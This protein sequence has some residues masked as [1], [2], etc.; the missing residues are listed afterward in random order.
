VNLDNRAR[1]RQE[2]R[3][4]ASPSG[5]ALPVSRRHVTFVNPEPRKG[6]HVF[7]RIAEVLSE[8][9]PD[10]PFLMV[11]GAAR[12]CLLTEIGIDLS[13]IRN[14]TVM[15]NTPDP[16]RFHAVTKLLLMPSLM[17]N[18]G[19]V[20]MEAMLNG[21]PVLASNRGGLPE[22]IGDAGFLFDIPAKYTPE[23]LDI[24]T[25]DEVEPWIETIVRLWDDEG[26]YAEWS[27]RARRRADRWRPERLAPAYREF[28]SHLCPQRGPPLLARTKSASRSARPVG[29][30]EDLEGAENPFF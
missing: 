1:E 28:F 19:L 7:A 25:A 23:T 6:I 24:A 21:I 20:A 30:P 10:I 29:S 3:P 5:E 11:E 8:R 22:T 9:R 16:R 27:E 13:R 15:P 14:L 2:L 26:Y 18:A 17:E 12:A 4:Y